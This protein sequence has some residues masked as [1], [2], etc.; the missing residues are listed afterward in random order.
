[1]FV[2]SGHLAA[3]GSVVAVAATSWPGTSTTTVCRSASRPT[4]SYVA[5]LHRHRGGGG[6]LRGRPDRGIGATVI[7]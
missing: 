1:M 7:P 4:E 2:F 6:L 5:H 3:A